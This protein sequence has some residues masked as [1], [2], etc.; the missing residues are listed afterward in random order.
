MNLNGPIGFFRVKGVGVVC[1]DNLPRTVELGRTGEGRAEFAYIDERLLPQE[2]R[3]ER[4][5]DW[6]VVVD[7][8][9]T[10]AVRGAP[11]IGVAGAAAVALWASNEGAG[12]A[13]AHGCLETAPRFLERLDEVAH[14]VSSARPTAV[15]LAWAVSHITSHAQ[16]LCADDSDVSRVSDALFN[17]VRRMAAED[18]AV[19][20]AMGAHG[21]QLLSPGSRVL[22]HCNAGSLATVFYGTALGVIYAAAEQGKIERVYADETRPVGQGARLTSWELSRAGVPVTLICDNMAASVMAQGLVDAV[23]VGA[24]RITA[25]G[26]VAN[27]I[28]TYGV[29]VLAKHHGIPFY[30]VAPTST[31]D[32]SLK[33]G[34]QIPIEHRADAEVLPEPIEGVEV[35]NPAFDVTPAELIAAIVT[36]KG[37]F[38]PADIS[39]ACS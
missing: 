4:T 11:A 20:R 9:K 22:T 31:V 6:R 27:K 32:L 3:T 8:I 23:F 12:E 37:V 7:A 15:N 35:L 33:R 19:N 38:A 36:E 5:Q 25:N 34:E 17:E 30:V 28:G 16:V 29:A 21:A 39:L 10:L 26:D 2:L 14:E 18:E 24:D 1:L 13:A